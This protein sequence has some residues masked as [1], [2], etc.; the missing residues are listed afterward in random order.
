MRPF[1]CVV[2]AVA[3]GC[4]DS[5]RPEKTEAREDVLSRLTSF[6]FYATNGKSE[7]FD[8]TG[9]LV[10]S[11]PNTDMQGVRFAVTGNTGTIFGNAGTAP[12]QV[13]RGPEVLKLT[14]KGAAYEHQLFVFAIE[15]P[16]GLKARY[17]RSTSFMG[18]TMRSIYEGYVVPDR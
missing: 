17:F 7:A 9:Q 4:H 3:L 13:Q 8:V 18:E 5:G 15:V 6:T 12:L 10:Q 11:T 1:Y 16:K 14:E 2:L